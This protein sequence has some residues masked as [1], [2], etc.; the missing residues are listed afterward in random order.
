MESPA[1]IGLIPSFERRLASFGEITLP[2]FTATESLLTQTLPAS[3]FVGIPASLNSLSTGPA[4]RP[5]FPAGTIMSSGATSPAL[6]GRLTLFFSSVRKS[7][8]GSRFEKIS[9]FCPVRC[10]RSSSAFFIPAFLRARVASVFLTTKTSAFPR[11]ARLT[12]IS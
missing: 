7:L 5:V 4:G 10:L 6:A 12:A 1:L 9:A 2:F 3:I 11:S 8:K